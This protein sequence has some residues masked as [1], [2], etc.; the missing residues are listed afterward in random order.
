MK[1]I[2]EFNWF[3]RLKF[4]REKMNC[5]PKNPDIVLY[6]VYIRVDSQDA[7]DGYGTEYDE[8]MKE[9]GYEFMDRDHYFDSKGNFWG[10]DSDPVW[11][12][13]YKFVNDNGNYEN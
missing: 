6:E 9:L 1:D 3:N 8:M 13:W 10:E 12:K 11:D 2:V 7:A 5:Y 4:F